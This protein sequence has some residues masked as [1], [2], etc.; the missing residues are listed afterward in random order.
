MSSQQNV[1][2]VMKELE[3]RGYKETINILSQNTQ[4][5]VTE[6]M[7]SNSMSQMSEEF[8]QRVGRPMTYSEMRSMGG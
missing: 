2:N 8:T 4:P 1:N 3:Q 5:K 7:L 6:K